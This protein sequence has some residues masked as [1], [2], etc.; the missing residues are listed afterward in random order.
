[1]KSAVLSVLLFEFV[2][3]YG[4][5]SARVEDNCDSPWTNDNHIE[6]NVL[7]QSGCSVT[8]KQGNDVY[9]DLW[10]ENT[11]IANQTLKTDFLQQMQSGALQAERYVNFTLQDIY[12]LQ[13]VTEMLWEM[14]NKVKEPKD[15]SDFMSGRYNSYNNF[16]VSCLKQFHIKDPSSVTPIPAMEKYLSTYKEVMADRDPVYFAVA[17]LPCSRLWP[18]LAKNLNI[19]KTNAYYTWK[20]SNSGGH[21]ETHFRLILDRYLNTTEKIQN[22]ERIFRK[23]M[24]NEHDFFNSS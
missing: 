19:T 7:P 6:S 18:W 17:L 1:M 3:S 8:A 15:M 14:K 22:A 20:E 24:Q 21:P 4:L 23:Q 11:D 13:K 10:D 12:Y 9:D 16:L 5:A 2:L